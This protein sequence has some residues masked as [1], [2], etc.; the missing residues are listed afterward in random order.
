MNEVTTTETT[1]LTNTQIAENIVKESGT[2][3]LVEKITTLLNEAEYRD[4]E[5]KSIRER[6]VQNNLRHSNFSSKVEE[7]LKQHIGDNDSASV[8]ELKE[9]AEELEL[10]M[11]KEIS[12]DVT[13]KATF[14]IRVPL[15]FDE[16]DIDETDFDTDIEYTGDHEAEQEECYVDG[17]KVEEA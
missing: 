9:L 4:S 15:D 12:V 5:L 8:D 6:M 11:T 10:E 1:P 13:V 17:F 3:Q 2:T 7:F 16:S 14:T